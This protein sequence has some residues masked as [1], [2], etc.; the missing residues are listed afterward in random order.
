MKKNVNKITP[1]FI[2]DSIG[3]YK[4]RRLK[5]NI[6]KYLKSIPEDIIDKEQKD[7]LDY[8]LH[9]PITTFPYDFNKSYVA[10]SINV[11]MDEKLGLKYVLHEGKRLYFKRKWTI[12]EIRVAYN[13]LQIEQDVNSPHRYLSL[14]FS[15]CD[16]AV[17]VDVGAGEGNF[18]LSV[19]ENASKLYLFEADNEWIEAL[20]ATF[21]PWKNKVVIVNKYVSDTDTNTHVSLDAFF[22]EEKIDFLKA[23]VEGCELQLLQGASNILFSQKDIMVAMCTYHRQN[24]AEM[25]NQALTQYGFDT[26][27]SKGYMFFFLDSPPVPPYLRKGLVRAVKR[28]ISN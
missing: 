7:V 11:H 17:T 15:V 9:N 10:Q 12:D 21:Q 4:L 6:I 20:N 2:K 26:K 8:L 22:K 1:Q 24:D 16:N 19:V 13:S 3:N 14:D 5:S 25:I 18:S 28:G 27:F 23:D